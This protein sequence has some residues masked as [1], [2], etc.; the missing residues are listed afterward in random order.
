M[1][2]ESRDNLWARFLPAAAMSRA[3]NV[4]PKHLWK[5]NASCLPQDE[6]SCNSEITAFTHLIQLQAGLATLQPARPGARLLQP[7][8]AHAAPHLPVLP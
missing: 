2:S 7:A 1:A 5:I 3:H 4:K 6:L 8:A